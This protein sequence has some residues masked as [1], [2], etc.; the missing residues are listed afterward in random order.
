MTMFKVIIMNKLLIKMT[1]LGFVFAVNVQAQTASSPK[2]VKIL[3]LRQCIELAMQK[4]MDIQVA[5][6]SIEKSRDLEGTAWNLDKTELVLSQ[7]P[8]AGGSPDNA[9]SLSQT[10]DFPSVYIAK[11]RQLKAETHAEKS[12]LDIVKASLAADVTGVYCQLVYEN[13]R[14]QI[15]SQQDSVLA[16]YKKIAEKR[17]QA[18]EI[19]RLEVLTA[20][21]LVR[22]NRL[23]MTTVQSEIKSVYLQ[24]ARLLNSDDIEVTDSCLMPLDHVMS[25][26]QYSQTPEGIYASDRLAVADK[27]LK[28]AKHG[29]VPSLSLSFR[30]QLV[31]SGW[32]PYHQDRTKFSGGNFMGFEVG[33]G[34]PIF[35]G[36][37]KA[38]VKVAKKERE[39]TEMKIKTERQQREREFNTALN[40]RNVAFS[41]LDYYQREGN[42]QAEEMSRL[43]TL[44]YQ[45]GEITYLEY[46]NVLKESI[47]LRLKYA[48]TVN[49]Y[50]Q[51]TVAIKRML[52]EF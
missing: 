21:R 37:T 10:L 49:E 15:L 43:G 1:I 18:G 6:K 38:K 16:N 14:L 4:N 51:S 11:K 24:L 50:N 39:I 7:D 45:N 23:E 32:N 47:D 13:R 40:R 17:Y 42:I 41:K 35:Y 36:A 9:I 27:A 33:I 3:N 19:R 8:T 34:V 52:G 20:D 26:Y 46:V 2:A 48:A 12:R 30:N 5:Q 44:E 25:E 31:I 22:E 28:V 29:F